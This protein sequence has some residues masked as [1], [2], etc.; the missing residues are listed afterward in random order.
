[1]CLLLVRLANTQVMLR[2]NEL[3]PANSGPTDAVESRQAK[4][5]ER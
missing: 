3:W 1:M 5:H 4:V 2:D